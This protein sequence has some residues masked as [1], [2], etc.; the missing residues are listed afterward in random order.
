[1]IESTLIDRQVSAYGKT[2]T[3]QKGNYK[4]FLVA[5]F[6]FTYSGTANLINNAKISCENINY[7]EITYSCWP[8]K[9]ESAGSVN[10]LYL[11]QP[12]NENFSITFQIT[13]TFCI[14]GFNEE[15]SITPIKGSGNFRGL[16][17]IETNNYDYL[18][19]GTTYFDS[20]RNKVNLSSH[21]YIYV[22]KHQ[23][24]KIMESAYSVVD[25]QTSCNG[26][27]R[28]FLIKT[29]KANSN[30]NILTAN[31]TDSCYICGVNIK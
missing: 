8:E 9:I 25:D 13:D 22:D 20:S 29:N 11:L 16:N 26:L 19:V 14:Y 27:Q 10:R 31:G 5:T 15:L 12:T 30:A 7:N 23:V 3:Y 4:T 17:S 21:A 1:M 18:L 24:E 6:Y 28:V 2:F